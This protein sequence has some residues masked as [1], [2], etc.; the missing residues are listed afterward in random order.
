MMHIHYPVLPCFHCQE[1]TKY[2]RVIIETFHLVSIESPELQLLLKQRSTDIG[3]VMKFACAVVVEDLSEDLRVPIEVV[4]IE[5]G[6]IVS[7]RLRQ[8]TEPSGWDFLQRGLV[9]LVTYTTHVQ[10]DAVVGVRHCNNVQQVTN[11]SAN[12]F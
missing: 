5:Y 9:R 4:F 11:Q 10:N 12:R 7:Q 2:S 3:G 1:T 6:I 8:P